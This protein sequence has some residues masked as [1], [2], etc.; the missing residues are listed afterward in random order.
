[1]ARIATFIPGLV[2]KTT[3]KASYK[4]ALIGYGNN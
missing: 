4:W 2:K 3:M 1:M